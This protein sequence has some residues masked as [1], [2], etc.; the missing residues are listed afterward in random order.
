LSYSLLK[1]KNE[2][3]DFLDQV[4]WYSIGK[5][6]LP[7][8]N[9][10]TLVNSSEYELLFKRTDTHYDWYARFYLEE[11]QTDLK[12]DINQVLEEILNQKALQFDQD[13]IIETDP[14]YVIKS[15]VLTASIKQFIR[16]EGMASQD[17]ERIYLDLV[18]IHFED[19]SLYCFESTS[20][21]LNG[22]V[23]GP[24]FEETLKLAQ[25]VN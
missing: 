12:L 15:E 3:K 20:S 10:W 17:I 18:L 5:F 13:A 9:W 2:K 25:L 16:V 21:V 6:K 1:I 14:R 8:A 23:E 4:N 22:S 11:K 24:F 19:D 7:I